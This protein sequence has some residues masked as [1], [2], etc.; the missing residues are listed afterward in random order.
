MVATIQIVCHIPAKK[1][2]IDSSLKAANTPIRGIHIIVV[3]S[4]HVIWRTFQ[5]YPYP[6]IPLGTYVV[7]QLLSY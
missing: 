4:G 1:P 5:N 2:L 6:Q 7:A 3:L